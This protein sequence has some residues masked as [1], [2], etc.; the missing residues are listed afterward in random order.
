MASYNM[1][2]GIYAVENNYLLK[3]I[4]RDEWGYDGLVISD[5]SAVVDLAKAISAGLDLEMPY[6]MGIHGKKLKKAIKKYD[7]NISELDRAV[8]NIL[9]TADKYVQSKKI[10]KIDISSHAN[11]A[12][13]V[14]CESAVLLKNENQLLPLDINNIHELTLIGGLAEHI[15]FQV[16][17]SSMVTAQSSCNLI[18]ALES[19]GIKVNYAQG[20]RVDSEKSDHQL[21]AEAIDL[22][23]NSDKVIFCGGLI[24]IIESEGYDRDHMRLPANQLSLLDKL[25]N[26]TDKMI[27]VSFSGSPY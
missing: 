8:N 18:E 21:T 22:V 1:V 3:K 25:T 15:R 7:L 4:L 6:N 13:Q 26:I 24:E 14:A 19:H 5:W 17:G 23:A 2:N 16:G 12:Y 9:K 27:Y 11:I 10:E 20:Y